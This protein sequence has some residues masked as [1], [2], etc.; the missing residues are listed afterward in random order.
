MIL[1][2]QKFAQAR[3]GPVGKCLDAAF[4][5]RQ[6][7]VRLPGFAIDFRD[8]EEGIS[9]GKVARGKSYISGPT[10]LKERRTKYATGVAMS[11]SS[12]EMHSAPMTAMASGRSMSAPAPMP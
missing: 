7:L 12:T 5:P 11:E 10:V 3:I 2:S 8:L 9:V 4:G 1:I 6:R